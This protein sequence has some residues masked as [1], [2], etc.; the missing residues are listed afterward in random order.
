MQ[1]ERE[2]FVVSKLTNLLFDVAKHYVRDMENAKTAKRVDKF[3]H[4]I[5]SL[6]HLIVKMD[7][8]VQENRRQLEELRTRLVWSLALNLISVVGIIVLVAQL[9]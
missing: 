5:S 3:A 7:T 9:F 8:K 1:K 2:G 6:E 4:K